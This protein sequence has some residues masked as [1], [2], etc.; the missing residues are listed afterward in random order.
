MG[1]VLVGTQWSFRGIAILSHG[2]CFRDRGRR[3]KDPR[4]CVIDL[5]YQ[6][7]RSPL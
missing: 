6:T 5:S 4:D 2:W 3:C 7:S 1:N